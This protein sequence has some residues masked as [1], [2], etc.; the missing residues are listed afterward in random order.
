MFR[1]MSDPARIRLTDLQRAMRIVDGIISESAAGGL[2]ADPAFSE[3]LAEAMA[4]WRVGEAR[5]MTDA[6]IAAHDAY[7]AASRTQ[8]AEDEAEIFNSVMAERPAPQDVD[9]PS[10]QPRP[11]VP[12][13]RSSISDPSPFLT[14]A[15]TA[16]P[17]LFAA[18]VTEPPW[19]GDSGSG[20]SF[21]GGGASGDFNG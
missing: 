14:L 12:L 4:R 15:T 9:I 3:R 7:V 17:V 6:E 8:F 20:G 2:H 10:A 19:A 13:G 18:S 11:L 1:G 5:D 21:G 16:G